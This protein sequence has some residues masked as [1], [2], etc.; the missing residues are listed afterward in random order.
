MKTNGYSNDLW[1]SPINNG[2][3]ALVALASSELG[4]GQTPPIT[5]SVQQRK[6]GPKT[7]PGSPPRG[8]KSRR[9]GRSSSSDTSSKA[10]NPLLIGDFHKSLL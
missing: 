10:S 3:D 2:F 7:P 9:R 6:S 5:K 1:K 8:R 4:R